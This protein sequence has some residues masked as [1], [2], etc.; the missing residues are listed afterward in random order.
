MTLRSG[1]SF[2]SAL[3]YADG[4]T[5]NNSDIVLLVGRILLAWI[6]VRSGYD[7]IFN[8]EAVANSFPM[9]GL[10]FFLAYVAVPFCGAG[11]ILPLF[12]R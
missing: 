8:V 9:R 6:F 3:S 11:R 10:P 1:N 5:T 4:L 7:K 2:H 12:S